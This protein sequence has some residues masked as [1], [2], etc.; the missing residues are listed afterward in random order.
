MKTTFRTRSLAATI[1]CASLIAGA[2]SLAAQEVRESASPA[3]ADV[4]SA[5]AWL[6]EISTALNRIAE[7]LEE[8]REGRG[9]EVLMK[10]IELGE[11]RLQPL[12]ARLHDLVSERATLEE[13]RTFA[14]ARSRN[15]A[16]AADRGEPE[17]SAQ[18]LEFMMTQVELERATLEP[19]IA[20]LDDEIATLQN[21]TA[22]QRRDLE[23][24]QA[25]VDRRLSGL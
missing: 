5:E 13:Q 20:A 2:T 16:D 17:M 12:E 4:R 11:R 8:Q 15:L 22:R 7:L 1:L 3:A 9:I 21:Q 14:E 25:Y 10:R 6:A 23:D 18:E 24:G 19:R